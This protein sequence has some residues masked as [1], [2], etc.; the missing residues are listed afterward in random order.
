M[1]VSVPELAHGAVYATWTILF[2]GALTT[3]TPMLDRRRELAALFSAGIALSVVGTV[4]QGLQ[5]LGILPGAACLLASLGLF[6]WARVSISG[7][8]FSYLGSRDTPQFVFT[9]GPYAYL[10][11]PFYTS[12][13]L[14]LL[15]GC[16]MFPGVLSLAGAAAGAAGMYGASRFEE[17]KFAKSPLAAEYA[18]YMQRT[19]RFFPKLSR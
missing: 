4:R 15:G 10:R 7:R 8:F 17:G 18:A 5:I 12:Y 6:G 19:G 2:F 14:A 9:G 11:H 3:F 13:L 1:A 16:L